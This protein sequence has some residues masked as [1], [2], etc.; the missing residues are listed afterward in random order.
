MPAGLHTLRDQSVRAAAAR[1]ARLLLGADH[2]E[3]VHALLGEPP[4]QTAVHAESDDRHVDSRLHA[5]LDVPA[6]DKRHQQVDRYR[7]VRGDLLNLTDRL[8][9]LPRWKQPER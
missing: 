5:H 3:Y 9:Q 4:E 8:P 2:H 1:P 6:T 7:A